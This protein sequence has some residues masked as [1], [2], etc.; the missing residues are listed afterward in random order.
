MV[1]HDFAGWATRNDLL[2]SDG[3]IIRRDAFIGDDG[4]EVPL[5]WNHQHNDP[6]NIL[7]HALLENRAEGVYAYC[8]FNDTESGNTAKLLVQHGDISSLSIY[9]NQLKQQGPNVIHG[10]IREVSLVLASANP[11]ASIESV[12]KHGEESDEEA[13]IYT[14]E[15]ICLYHADKSDEEETTK[16]ETTTVSNEK[17]KTTPETESEDKKD[18]EENGPTIKEVYESMN[19]DQKKCVHIMVGMAV[20][21]AQSKSK[22]DDE[23]KHSEGGDESMK[24]NIFD[25]EEVRE[26]GII[27]HA[28]QEEI[29][30]NAK[31]SNV[32]TFK[33][34]MKHY[35]ADNDTLQHGIDEITELFPEYHNITP[36]APELVRADQ[37]WVMKVINKIHKSPY[38]RVRT[39]QADA[40][41]AEL[42][43]KGYNNR[44]EE[45]T[46]SANIK[47]LGRTFDPQT[48]YRKDTLHRDDITDITD[49]DAVNY[50]WGIMR[51]NM[52]EELALAALVGDGRDDAD[53]DKIHENHVASIW[54]DEELY[55][56]HRD[57]DFN[58]MK[59][60]LQGSN[61]GA[62]FGDEYIRAEAIIA[63]ALYAREKF[64][65]SG[66]PDFYCAPHTVNVMLLARDLNG[67]RIYESKAALAT[68]LNV[69]EIIE[70]EQLDG[71]VRTDKKGGEHKLLGI[72]VNLSDYQFGST[73]GGELT[74]FEDFDIDF[75]RYKY[76]METR[77]SGGL[78][79][80]LSAIALEEP[81]TA[82]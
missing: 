67:R 21:E 82:G 14:G 6:N 34:A 45:K 8:S 24:H 30:A 68:A 63:E 28:D 13:V 36:G 31:A 53:P 71:K 17:E 81:V 2:C 80:V 51:D 56:L 37:S 10:T 16:K 44:E 25:Q 66:Q 61:T 48:I 46:L 50:I 60:K 57:I 79:K 5:V 42:R 32:G 73:K 65:G 49:F 11:G 15:D 47:L 78:T 54:N 52:Y 4:Q 18:S 70:I 58:V 20:E 59:T 3:R 1:K 40:R 35:A 77:L 12:I 19:E 22:E 55:T 39:R 74:K 72:F 23:V 43:A 64:K 9:A 62:N 38:S 7:G 76:L 69:K 26:G 27:C 33:T 75:N 29:L 41:I